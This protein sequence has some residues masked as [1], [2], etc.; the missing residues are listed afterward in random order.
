MVM[1]KATLPFQ[2]T[3]EIYGTTLGLRFVNNKLADMHYPYSMDETA[4]RWPVAGTSAAKRKRNGLSPSQENYFA[5][6]ACLQLERNKVNVNGGSAALAI[7][8]VAV[9]CGFPQG[10]FVK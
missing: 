2:R 5:A 3:T 6:L 9:V 7:L 1:A 10:L 4:G 8:W